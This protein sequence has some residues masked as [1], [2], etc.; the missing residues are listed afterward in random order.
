MPEHFELSGVDL[1]LPGAH[2]H[3]PGDISGGI[4]YHDVQLTDAQIKALPTTPVVVLPA[5]AAGY[6]V[7]PLLAYL[8]CDSSAGAYIVTNQP[9]VRLRVRG[10]GGFAFVVLAEQS[11]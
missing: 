10:A 6:T 7:V 5:Q 1:H 9:F 3:V 2:T 11:T 8:A 4:L